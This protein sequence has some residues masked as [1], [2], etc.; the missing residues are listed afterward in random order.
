[1]VILMITKDLSYQKYK[2]FH[3]AILHNLSI[4]TTVNGYED[5]GN[6][7]DEDEEN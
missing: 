1:M 7:E 2:S 4:L 3:P 6:Y 5:N